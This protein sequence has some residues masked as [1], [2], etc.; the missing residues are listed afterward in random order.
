MYKLENHLLPYYFQASMFRRQSE[1]HE[2]NTRRTIDYRNPQSR[3]IYVN[4]SIRHRLPDLY[5]NCPL[6]IKEKVHTHS[7]PGFT[8]YIKRHIINSYSATSTTPNCYV[9][10]NLNQSRAETTT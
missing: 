7:F 3:H 10:L 4:K 1:F 9:C 2:Y 8:K 6:N 5:N